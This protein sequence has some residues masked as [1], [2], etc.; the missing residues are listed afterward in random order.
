MQNGDQ[1]EESQEQ[2]PAE[3]VMTG[4]PSGCGKNSSG[5]NR[6]LWGAEWMWCDDRLTP[7]VKKGRM[8][9]VALVSG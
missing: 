9:G 6:G 5:R 1:T 7:V 2:E 4:L 8:S 3:A